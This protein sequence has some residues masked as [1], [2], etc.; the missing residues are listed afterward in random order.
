MMV[1]ND[2]WREED[3]YFDFRKAKSVCSL[4]NHGLGHGMS[5][6]MKS[7]D[8]VVEWETQF[9]LV[10]VK[11]PENSCIPLQH[12]RMQ[13]DN[14]I[15]KIQSKSLVYNELFPKFID[16]LLY[17]GLDRGIPAKPLR[18]L[19]LISLSS[20]TPIDFNV[21]ADT[22]LGYRDG[23]LLGPQTGWSKGFSVHLFNL[24]FWNKTFPYCPV[25]R[26]GTTWDLNGAK[27]SEGVRNIIS[28]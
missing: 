10:E 18:Y 12:K 28:C 16:S 13:Q 8:F 21:L 2:A 19:I 14:F 15:E 25:T 26:V 27:E 1:H 3:L 7:V 9:W 5:R 20:L 17:L 23:Y 11:D 6:L 22:L 4:D 24:E